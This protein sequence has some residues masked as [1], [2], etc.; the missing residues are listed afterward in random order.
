MS[1]S[2]LIGQKG[3]DIAVSYIKNKEYIVLDRNYHSRFGEIDIIAKKENYIVFI[4]VK[5]RHENAM[6]TAFESVDMIKQKKIIKTA[7]IYLMKHDVNLQPRFD[8]IEVLFEK[9]SGSIKAVNQIE[10]AFLGDDFYETF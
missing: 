10:N 7:M 4:E 5:T 8:V 9:G 6:V 1:K 3:E 2:R